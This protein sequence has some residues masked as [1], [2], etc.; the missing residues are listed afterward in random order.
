MNAMAATFTMTAITTTTTICIEHTN[1]E[2]R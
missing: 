1:C 2:G